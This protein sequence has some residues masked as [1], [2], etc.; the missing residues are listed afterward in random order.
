MRGI[1]R[2]LQRQLAITTVFVTHDQREACEIGDQVAILLDGR[3][4]QA[5][6]PR[7]FYTDPASEPV[8]RFFGWCVVE[9]ST[10]DRGVVAFHPS[11]AT[12]CSEHSGPVRPGSFPVVVEH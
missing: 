3:V 10:P 11:A 1:I 7:V 4:A 2:Q 8:A 6:A 5:G 9:T 12:L